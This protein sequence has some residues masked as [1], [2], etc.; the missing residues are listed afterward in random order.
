VA[1]AAT[2]E[3][4]GSEAELQSLGL[5]QVKGR[6]ARVEAFAVVRLN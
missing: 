5:V 4:L 1:G 6:K 3:A 2:A